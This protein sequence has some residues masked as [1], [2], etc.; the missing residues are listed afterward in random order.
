MHQGGK[1]RAVEEIE[2]IVS[3]TLMHTIDK[4]IVMKVKEKLDLN[5]GSNGELC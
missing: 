4:I 3:L 5:R 2:L 1:K